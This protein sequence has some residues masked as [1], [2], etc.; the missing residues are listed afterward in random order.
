M[1]VSDDAE[2]AQFDLAVKQAFVEFQQHGLLTFM[3]TLQLE[4]LQ[5]VAEHVTGVVSCQLCSCIQL[6]EHG[7]TVADRLVAHLRVGPRQAAEDG[8]HNRG[9]HRL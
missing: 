2:L 9:E 3:L 6:L 1:S 4:R 7:Q 5:H 8:D